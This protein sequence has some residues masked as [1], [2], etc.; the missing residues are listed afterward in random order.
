MRKCIGWGMALCSF[1]FNVSWIGV[2]CGRAYEVRNA[3]QLMER[4]ASPLMDQDVVDFFIRKRWC[5]S[6]CEWPYLLLNTK[7]N[8]RLHSLFYVNKADVLLALS[9][10][11]CATNSCA[12]RTAYL[13]GA[14]NFVLSAECDECNQCSRVMFAYNGKKP[15]YFDLYDIGGANDE[16]VSASIKTE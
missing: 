4:H 14:P 16:D 13:L 7:R 10:E 9:A 3:Y 12:K 1:A 6:Y 11:D 8:D 2:F 15:I 5:V